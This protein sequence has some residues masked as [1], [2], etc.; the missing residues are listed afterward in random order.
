M[1]YIT[2]IKQYLEISE[3]WP[4]WLNDPKH[5]QMTVKYLNIQ[6]PLG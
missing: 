4:D 1:Q 3:I 6:F 5:L 2:I